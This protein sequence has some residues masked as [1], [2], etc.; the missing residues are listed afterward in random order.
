[1]VRL[2][3][4][5]VLPS[6]AHSKGAMNKPDRPP[7]DPR[8]YELIASAWYVVD[9]EYWL[10]LAS[11]RFPNVFPKDRPLPPKQPLQFLNLLQVYASRLLKIEADQYGQFKNDENY[12]YWLSTLSERIVE[13]VRTV[14]D[15]IRKIDLTQSFEN[16]GVSELEIIYAVRG[17][18]QELI[19]P[20]TGGVQHL[21]TPGEIMAPRQGPEEPTVESYNRQ[22]IEDF[23]RKCA[24][25]GLKIKRKDIWR[26]AGYKDRTEFE[27]FQRGDTRNKSASDALNR[28]LG[29]APEQFR[30]LL[31]KKT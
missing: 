6:C 3:T 25:S 18:L 4:L 17:T 11:F 1:M 9:Q 27:R 23:I 7:L 28:T 19:N 8:V 10:V 16:Q 21:P 26:V 20:Y 5:I 13:H 2:V 24:E 30:S 14:V 22:R 15:R 29:F 12:Q 31:N